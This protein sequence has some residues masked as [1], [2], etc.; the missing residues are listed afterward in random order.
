MTAI[1]FLITIVTFTDGTSSTFVK[2]VATFQHI[3]Y[4]YAFMQE[5]HEE[6]P[7]R[8]LTCQEYRDA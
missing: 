1:L 4:C 7:D 6:H 2:E 8:L 3:D 5:L